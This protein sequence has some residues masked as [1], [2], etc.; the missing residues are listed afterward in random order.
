MEIPEP[1]EQHQWLLQLLGDWSYEHDC[2]MGP[3]QPPM[4]CSGQQTT[5]ALGQLWIL[6]EMTGA[7]P[8][9]ESSSSVITLGYDPAQERF[10]GTFVSSCMTHL[11]PYRGTLD[12]AR[13]VLTLDSEGPSF[14]GDGTMAKYQDIIEIIDIDHYTMTS[15]LQGP[16]GQWV[17]FMHGAYRRTGA[18][19]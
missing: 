6:T 13:K 10:V 17:R 16:D 18:A 9:G 12:A 11:W 4:K 7:L 14:S 3:D 19:K 5:R 2:D 1:L 8:N 15:Q